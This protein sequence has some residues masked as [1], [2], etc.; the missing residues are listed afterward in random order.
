MVGE[1]HGLHGS[2]E[3]VTKRVVDQRT[4]KTLSRNDYSAG[5]N[6]I[7]MT[8]EEGRKGK[9]KGGIVSD[10]KQTTGDEKSMRRVSEG[11]VNGNFRKES[12]TALGTPSQGE[13]IEEM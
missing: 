4:L 12:N 1:I 9:K 11:Y 8:R 13:S 6:R 10:S 3:N 7:W 5:K 2:V